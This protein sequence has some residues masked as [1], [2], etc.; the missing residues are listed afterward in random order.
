MTN[1]IIHIAKRKALQSP[2]RYKISAL[3]F[4]GKGECIYRACNRPRFSRKGGGVHAEMDVMANA[5]PSLRYILICRVNNS[6]DLM[7]IDPCTMCKEKANE[8]GIKITTIPIGD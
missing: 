1:D 4:N 7:P 2:C 8:L 3:G 6:G 5:G